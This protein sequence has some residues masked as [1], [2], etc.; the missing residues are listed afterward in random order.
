M[1]DRIEQTSS[2]RG[3]VS[4]G[5]AELPGGV[6]AG[7]RL[8]GM[9]ADGTAHDLNGLLSAMSMYAH[10]V[11]RTAAAENR[12]HVRA[13]KGLIVEAGRTTIEMMSLVPGRVGPVRDLDSSVRR[14]I[15][16]AS[17]HLPDL[18]VAMA[19]ASQS[20]WVR[21]P[22]G[23]VK[24]ALLGLWFGLEASGAAR[25]QVGL[26]T[27]SDEGLAI[28]RC[29]VLDEQGEAFF[30]GAVETEALVKSVSDLGG[31]LCRADEGVFRLEL[32]MADSVEAAEPGVDGGMAQ[33]SL[34]GHHVVVLAQ[35]AF[36]LYLASDLL[37]T[38]GARVSA[39]TGL[40]DAIRALPDDVHIAAV[41]ATDDSLSD[42]EELATHRGDSVN[43]VAIVRLDRHV[44]DL[45]T[46]VARACSREP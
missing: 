7:L 17:R 2:E 24:R 29:T 44:S 18:A 20:V 37:R 23:G 31:L 28:V 6:E 8:M 32:P 11:E 3:E 14:A 30:P 27:D 38:T 4:S 35:D 15:R 13:L 36:Q 12:G 33:P 45:P 21:E 10:L 39:F 22:A 46:C 5:P 42:A 43:P 1:K 9:I 19:G 25:I 40:P 16:L 26:G 34:S 41:V